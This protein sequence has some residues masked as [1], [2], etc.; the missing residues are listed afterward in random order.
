MK[1]D[2]GQNGYI[3]YLEDS[4]KNRLDS[5]VTSLGQNDINT[6]KY[7]IRYSDTQAVF[8]TSLSLRGVE[9]ICPE[10]TVQT[11]QFA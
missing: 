11:D 3:V 7:S 10:I 6:Q 2:D 9:F 5:S 8:V 1:N 4:N